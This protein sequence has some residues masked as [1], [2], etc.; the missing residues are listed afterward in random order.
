MN[1]TVIKKG[2]GLS[3][4]TSASVK[5]G[6]GTPFTVNDNVLNGAATPFL[7]FTATVSVVPVVIVKFRL[8]DNRVCKL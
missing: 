6:A 7:L 5:N 8:F 2:T 3:I 1:Y 4:V